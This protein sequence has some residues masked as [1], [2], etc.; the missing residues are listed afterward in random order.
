MFITHQTILDLTACLFLFLSLLLRDLSYA[1][2]NPSLG[3]FVCWMLGAHA[4]TTTAANASVGGLIIITLERY[5]KIVHSVA[6]RNHYRP[7]MTRLGIIIPWIFGICTGF[8]PILATS[9][10][11]RGSCIK[12]RY[13]VSEGIR[14]VWG[15]AKFLLLYLGPLFVFILGYRFLSSSPENC[16]R[17][18]SLRTDPSC[19][20]CMGRQTRAQSVPRILENPD[21][22]SSPEKSSRA[23]ST[24]RNVGLSLIHI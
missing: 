6:Y 18:T 17:R 11:V 15:I 24:R 3:L 20:E 21:G 22:D 9:K 1:G 14:E 8:I 23:R 12:N 5:I 7:W 4:I 19:V 16:L 2:L 10:V 13:Y